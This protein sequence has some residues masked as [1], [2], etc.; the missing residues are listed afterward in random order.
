EAWPAF[1]TSFD[2]MCDLLAEVARD[3]GDRRA[4]STITVVSGDIHFAYV[5]DVELAHGD[6]RGAVTVHQVVSSPMRNALVTNERRAIHVASWRTVGRVARALAR[7]AG[8]TGRRHRFELTHGPYFNNNIGMLTYD[9]ARHGDVVVERA[10][11]DDGG[12]PLLEIVIDAE[13]RATLR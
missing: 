13:L 12:D 5:G 1:R 4:P 8:R 6:P 7:L 9:D 2:E 3:A 10:R 11:S